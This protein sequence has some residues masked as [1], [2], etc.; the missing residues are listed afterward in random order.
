MPND[1][2]VTTAAGPALGNRL[3]EYLGRLWELYLGR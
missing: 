1:D 3:E 2:D